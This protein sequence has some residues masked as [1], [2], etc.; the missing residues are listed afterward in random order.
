MFAD[1]DADFS[2]A[3]DV[4]Q[5]VGRLEQKDENERGRKRCVFERQADER[6]DDAV[7]EFA[8]DDLKREK[9]RDA[10]ARTDSDV[11]R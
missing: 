7:S 1:F 4:L 10:D 6:L 2:D 3:A 5:R 11:E 9:D 8:D